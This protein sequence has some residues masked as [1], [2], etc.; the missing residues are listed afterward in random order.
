ML[1]GN[2]GAG[3]T[4]LMLQMIRNREKLFDKP[5]NKIVYCYSVFQPIFNDFPEVTFHEGLIK[6]VEEIFP[7]SDGDMHHILVLDD[8]IMQ[9]NDPE[10]G[11]IISKLFLIYSHHLHVNVYLLSQ[12]L[13]FQNKHMR[14]ISL[15]TH[16]IFL[17][18][19]KRDVTQVKR[20]LTQLAPGKTQLLMDTYNKITN[21]P[22]SYACFDLSP[23]I[24]E[25]FIIRSEILP[26]EIENISIPK[27]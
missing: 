12:N 6:N 10:D 23:G 8:Q 19:M 24:E 3:K 15:N 20:F 9:L 21:K 16:Y 11:K 4:Y 26:G 7:A 25:S 14:N 2:S 17:F 22:Y 18:R 5:I 13:F 1:I 27:S